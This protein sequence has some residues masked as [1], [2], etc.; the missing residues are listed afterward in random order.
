[1]TIPTRPD[2]PH[3]ETP[4]RQPAPKRYPVT[5]GELRGK[6]QPVVFLRLNEPI[7]HGGPNSVLLDAG[8]LVAVQYWG[9]GA[10][11]VNSVNGGP[12]VTVV[13]RTIRGRWPNADAGTE[14]ITAE[15][16]A[17]L[18]P[19][20]F[21]RLEEAVRDNSDGSTLEAGEQ[22]AIQFWGGGM[23]ALTSLRTGQR[24]VARTNT[25]HVDWDPFDLP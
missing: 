9:P 10:A 5:T 13:D 21:G 2:V 3:S 12:A 17:H 24:V 15:L 6:L 8:T 1:M 25:I 18:Q 22:V 19:V 20:I 23:T 4:P 11:V 14:V 16:R 7:T